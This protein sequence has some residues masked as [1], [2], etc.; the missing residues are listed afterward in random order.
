VRELEAVRA[1]KW[2][3]MYQSWEKYKN[4]EKLR[5]RTFKGIPNKVRGFFWGLL[6]D[7]PTVKMYQKGKYE[8]SC[9]IGQSL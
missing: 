6:L 5:K 9:R 3:K 7:V 4:S 1:D 2:M 8:V